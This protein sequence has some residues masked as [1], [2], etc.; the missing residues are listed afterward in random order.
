MGFAILVMLVAVVGGT[1]WYLVSVT[2][3]AKKKWNESVASQAERIGAEAAAGQF[4]FAAL[5]FQHDTG[6]AAAFVL[7]GLAVEPPIKQ[8]TRPY[9]TNAW[10]TTFTKDR[11]VK[12]GPAYRVTAGKPNK[13]Q[14]PTGDPD[15]D[16]THAVEPLLGTAPDAIV[17]AWT[18]QARTLMKRSGAR[19]EVMTGGDI[20]TIVTQGVVTEPDA[21]KDMADLAHELSR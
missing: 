1:V 17:S 9:N 6:P 13:S 12:G 2:S 8:L 21:I 4:G 3:G 20:I 7:N 18:E 11:P 16:T 15:F 10:V 5:R 14:L 19:F